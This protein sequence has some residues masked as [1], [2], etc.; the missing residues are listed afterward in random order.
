ML[1]ILFVCEHNSARSQMAEAFLKRLGGDDFAVKSCGIEAGVINPLVVEAMLE[2]GYDLSQ[3]TTQTAFNLFK[4]GES[5]DIVITVC[6]RK[7]SEQCPIF[8]GKALRMNWPFADPSI[9]EGDK[10]AKLEAIRNIRDQIEERIKIF[11]QEYRGN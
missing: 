4:Q 6:S 11:I 5:F 9:I 3:N 7:A 10:T 1:R 8:P 2:K